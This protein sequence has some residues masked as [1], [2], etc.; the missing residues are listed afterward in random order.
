MHVVLQ[1]G[2]YYL[3]DPLKLGKH[4]RNTTQ[5]L[6]GLGM[7]TLIPTNGKPV[8]EVED[9]FDARVAGLLLEASTKKT[10]QLLK[11]GSKTNKGNKN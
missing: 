7:A 11:W 9:G 1:P 2:N 3:A 10:D 4:G 5:V 6:L 8:V